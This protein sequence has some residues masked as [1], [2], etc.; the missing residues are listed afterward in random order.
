MAAFRELEAATTPVFIPPEL[1]E[2]IRR[3]ADVH[4]IRTVRWWSTGVPGPRPGR[5]CSD[6][7]RLAFRG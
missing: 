2:M 6:D 4:R 1:P 5:G 7:L 3:P